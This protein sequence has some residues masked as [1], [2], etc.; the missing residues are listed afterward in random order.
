MSRRMAALSISVAVVFAT[1]SNSMYSRPANMQPPQGVQ[2][3]GNQSGSLWC[4]TSKPIKERV[5][6]LVA[7]LTVE[8]KA[9]L[10]ADSAA[11][12]PRLDIPHYGVCGGGVCVR[13][14]VCGLCAWCVCARV[15]CVRAR[16]RV[17]VFMCK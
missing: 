3:N 13:A 1:A 4:D 2:C 14:C 16:A 17:Y 7:A 10:F 9:G 5:A 12:V 15:V 11:A 6:A 8:E